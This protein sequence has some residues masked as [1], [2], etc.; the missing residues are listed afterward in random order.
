MYSH[1]LALPVIHRRRR[2][3]FLAG[4]TQQVRTSGVLPELARACAALAAALAR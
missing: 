1:T 4:I 2:A 3:F